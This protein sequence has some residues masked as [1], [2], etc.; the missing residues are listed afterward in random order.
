METEAVAD[1]SHRKNISK[2]V[3]RVMESH[4][5]L[6]ILLGA[7]QTDSGPATAFYRHHQRQ[8][9]ARY[10]RIPMRENDQYWLDYDTVATIAALVIGLGIVEL[11]VMGI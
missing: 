6:A 11:L 9:P 4:R 5:N 10:G 1:R 2:F 7:A 8:S 3:H